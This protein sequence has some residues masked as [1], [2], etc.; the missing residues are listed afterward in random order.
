MGNVT[1]GNVASNQPEAVH[2]GVNAARCRISIS[3]TTSAGDVLRIGK[4][5]HQAAVL[6]VVFY[7]GAAH[8]NNTILKFGV[9]GSEAAFLT[10]DT[11]SVAPGIYRLDVNPIDLTGILS[12]S[13]DVAQRFTYITCTPTSVVTAGH[14]G[15]LVVYYKMPGQAV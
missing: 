11:Y 13:D 12:R 1:L 6:D 4:L 9:S 3:A 10:S 7:A 8:A 2:A 15:T 5:P 14:L